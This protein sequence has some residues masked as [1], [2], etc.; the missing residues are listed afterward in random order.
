M[1][2]GYKF[3]AEVSIDLFV[4]KDIHGQR[5]KVLRMVDNWTL[6]HSAWL[7][8]E[9]AGPPASSLCA[10]KIQNGWFNWAEK[11][12][13]DRG[14]ENRGKMLEMLKAPGVIVRFI[15]VQASHQLGRGERQGFI[16]KDKEMAKHIIS[17]RQIHGYHD[18]SYVITEAVTVKNNRV[19]HA[20]F[21]PSQWV[22]GKM[23]AEIDS[24]AGGHDPR[25]H[26]GQ[27]QEIHDGETAFSR[28]MIIRAAARESFAS[29]D[30]S[31]RIRAAMLRKTTPLRGPF[32]AGDLICFHR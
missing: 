21:T 29:V 31:E 32:S 2:G 12:V 6:F 26:I 16:L 5:Y 24:L 8:Q 22:L 15:G 28:Q 11:V 10:E 9:G 27:H 14:M 4:I 17:S 25:D 13:M 30:S 7:V 20:G 1:P 19:H 18:M 23:P 3:N